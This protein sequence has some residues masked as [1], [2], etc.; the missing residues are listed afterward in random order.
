MVAEAEL[1]I[2]SKFFFF[3]PFI[4][5]CAPPIS[6]RKGENVEFWFSKILGPYYDSSC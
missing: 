2:Y 6:L 5:S 1:L 4:F 3:I